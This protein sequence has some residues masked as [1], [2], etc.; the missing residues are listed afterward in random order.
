MRNIMNVSG[1]KKLSNEGTTT[2]ELRMLCE[3]ILG[4]YGVPLIA[5]ELSSIL[6]SDYGKNITAN[7]IANTLSDDHKVQRGR[8]KDIPLKTFKSL[9]EKNDMGYYEKWWYWK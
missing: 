4:D 8:F 2:P 5:I 1:L 6:K 9:N 3:K 7:R